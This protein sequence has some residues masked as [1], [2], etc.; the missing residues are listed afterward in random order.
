MV[1]FSLLTSC[2][3]PLCSLQVQ[4]SGVF[5]RPVFRLAVKPQ[6]CQMSLRRNSAVFI[7]TKKPLSLFG[8]H[9][10]TSRVPSEL[11]KASTGRPAVLHT[12]KGQAPFSSDRLDTADSEV[13]RSIS[14]GAL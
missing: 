2:R 6:E 12:V 9:P 14:E 10:N 11:L 8:S 13:R 4:C 7:P 5:P 1:M 3:T